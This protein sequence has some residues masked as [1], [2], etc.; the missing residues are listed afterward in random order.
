MIKITVAFLLCCLVLSAGQLSAAE[1]SVASPRW[2]IEFK[3]GQFQPTLSDWD[4]YYGSDSMHQFVAALG[5]MPL[6]ALQIGG[7]VGYSYDIGQGTLPSS[8]ALGGE[9]K[10]TLMPVHVYLLL[11]GAFTERQWLIPYVGGG[12]TYLYYKQ[13]VV[14]QLETKG[15][16]DGWNARAGLQLLV[17]SWDPS[18]AVDIKNSFGVQYTYLTLEVQKFSAK[19][20][21]TELGGESYLLGMRFE[22]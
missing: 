4:R 13:K 22:Y 11:R 6:R 14:S 1:E 16:A 10:Y 19:V 3:D 20:D 2:T 17:N 12:W 21:G 9:V 15:H 5:F 8:G 7:E 18:A